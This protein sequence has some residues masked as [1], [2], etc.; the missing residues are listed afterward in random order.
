MGFMSK[1]ITTR[2]PMFD[3]RLILADSF[4]K[5][6]KHTNKKYNCSI[7]DT[8]G[9]KGYSGVIRN[10]DSGEEVFFIVCEHQTPEVIAHECCHCTFDVLQYAQVKFDAENNEHFCYL[11][12]SLIHLYYKK[13][14][15]KKE[16]VKV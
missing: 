4:K 3:F 1:L 5:L 11:L 13:M 12:G 9:C 7:G 6:E 2:V 16:E 15:N 10:K 8:S 14:M